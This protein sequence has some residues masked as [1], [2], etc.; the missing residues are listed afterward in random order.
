V[1]LLINDFASFLGILPVPLNLAGGDHVV[2]LHILQGLT[3]VYW[4]ISG[5]YNEFLHG[6]RLEGRD[7]EFLVSCG[8]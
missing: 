6:Q 8:E 3:Q 2:H 4:R 7:S 5:V 1:F